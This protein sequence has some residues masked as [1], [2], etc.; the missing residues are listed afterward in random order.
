MS[1]PETVSRKRRTPAEKKTFLEG[2]I[3]ELQEREEV[4]IKLRLA[5]I[6]GELRSLSEMRPNEKGYANV[7]A[8]VQGF[9]DAIR[10]TIPQ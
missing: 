2:Q 10:V 8:T 6:A 5:R 3:R 7:A 4:K 1:D 9:A